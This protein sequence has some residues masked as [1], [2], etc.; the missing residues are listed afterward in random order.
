[1]NFALSDLERKFLNEILKGL[2]YVKS[3]TQV[4]TISGLAID[5]YF[6]SGNLVPELEAFRIESNISK[7]LQKNKFVKTPTDEVTY[8]FTE[9]GMDLLAFESLE[10]YEANLATLIQTKKRKKKLAES[11]DYMLSLVNPAH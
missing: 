10:S 1:M 4:F 6:T 2:Q 8:S 7:F 5:S 9:K 3:T 11:F